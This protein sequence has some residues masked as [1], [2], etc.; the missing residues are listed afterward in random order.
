MLFN[1]TDGKVSQL[2]QLDFKLERELQNFF[3]SNM[4]E[5]TGYK[6][7]KSEFAIDDYRLDSVAFDIENNAFIIVEY[8]R[9][10]NESLVD[11]GYAYLNKLLNR[12]A[13]FVLLFNEVMNESKLVKNFDWSQTRIVFVSPK[14]TKNQLDATAFT[15]MAFELYEVKK[16]ENDLYQVNLINQ[17]KVQYEETNVK[18]ENPVMKKVNREIVVYS[19]ETLFGDCTQTTKDLYRELDELIMQIDSELEPRFNKWYLGYKIDSTHNVV[20][21]W[22][23]KDWI[24]VVLN[25][26]LGEIDDPYNIMYDITNRKWPS[27]HYAV[28]FDENMNVDD[29]VD[30]IRRS[31]KFLKNKY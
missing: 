9:G 1:V 12:K 29:V 21:L 8:K 16:Y 22:P 13:D 14:F 28:H 18:I 25:V 31:Y 27:A 4:R 23:K 7:L 24:E 11:Q 10:K 17:K 30:L 19:E 2:K 26:K 6:F 5:I 3:E 15:N 20:S